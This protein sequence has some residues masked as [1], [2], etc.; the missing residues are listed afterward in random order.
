MY[1]PPM[2]EGCRQE[3][4]RFSE[5]QGRVEQ[6]LFYQTRSQPGSHIDNPTGNDE[7][8]NYIDAAIRVRHLSRY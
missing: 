7:G 3:A 2:Q 6:E 5:S 1:D 4:P 8:V